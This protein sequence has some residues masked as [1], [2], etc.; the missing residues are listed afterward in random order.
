M[1][2]FAFPFEK[3][4]LLLFQVCG[5]FPKILKFQEVVICKLTFCV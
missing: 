2:S 3:I 5:K 1:K 4:P